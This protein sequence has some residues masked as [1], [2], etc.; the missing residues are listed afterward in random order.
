M[1]SGWDEVYEEKGREVEG[2][3]KEH[4]LRRARETIP[5]SWQNNEE[6]PG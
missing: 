5:P 2:R 6:N 3:E 4:G 1:L